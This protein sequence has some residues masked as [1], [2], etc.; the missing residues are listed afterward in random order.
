MHVRF[1]RLYCRADKWDRP[2]EAFKQALGIFK[3][4]IY[5]LCPTRHALSDLHHFCL[6]SLF[7]FKSFGKVLLR[8]EAI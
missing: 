8:A 1:V 3:L 7:N 6:C 5:K 4:L 2:I